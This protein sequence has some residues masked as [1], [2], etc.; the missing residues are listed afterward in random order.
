MH[1]IHYAR[2]VLERHNLDAGRTLT[3]GE[4]VNLGG[5]R[6]LVHRHDPTRQVKLRFDLDLSGVKWHERFPVMEFPFKTDASE[7][8][9]RFDLST[10]GLDVMSGWV[11]VVVG[12]DSPTS[13]Q[14]PVVL[15]YAVGLDDIDLARIEYAPISGTGSDV[16]SQA[17]LTRL[18]LRHPAIAWPEEKNDSF[19]PID[20][21]F[22][23]FR[24]FLDT[25]YFGG[26]ELESPSAKEL[27]A[28]ARGD[29][30][31]LEGMT[32][33]VVNDLGQFAPDTM[34]VISHNN[35]GVEMKLWVGKKRDT[36]Q[37]AFF[38]AAIDRPAG[39]SD[40]DAQN[41]LQGMLSG[42]FDRE[43]IFVRI[44]GTDDAMPDWNSRLLLDFSEIPIDYGELTDEDPA[45]ARDRA[46]EYVEQLLTRLVTGPGEILR[47]VLAGFRYV[48]PMREIPPT[49]H[50]PPRF[51]DPSRWASGLAA[52]DL[53][54]DTGRQ[55][56]VPEVSAWLWNENR[57]NTGH[58]LIELVPFF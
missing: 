36:G 50:I 45:L 44:V 43:D 51:P 7:N 28:I 20:F 27:K 42:F 4:S 19:G 37:L 41:L 13:D 21:F 24:P 23:E 11:E 12:Y 30:S 57:L 39:I 33:S 18:N 58:Q 49:D 6:E 52:W 53:L 15:A 48:G 46:L 5:F 34:R 16:E 55:H 56:L 1:A 10:I 3:G 32:V 17:M 2:E 9:P 54:A 22:P 14:R 31:H 8:A 25:V 38:A 26:E 40:G 47:E 29:T 35:D